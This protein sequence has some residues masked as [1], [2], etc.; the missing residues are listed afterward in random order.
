MTND[1][2]EGEGDDTYKGRKVN[3]HA[4]V[5]DLVELV[6]CGTENVFV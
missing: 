1:Q 6:E 5:G 4:G 2:G 3:D